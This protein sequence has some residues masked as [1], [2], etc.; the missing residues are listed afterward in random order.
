MET[1]GAQSWGRQSCSAKWKIEG[2]ASW[3]FREGD[4]SSFKKTKGVGGGQQEWALSMHKQSCVAEGQQ[5]LR[6]Q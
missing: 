5:N 3:I 2:S 4:V 1:K 6:I